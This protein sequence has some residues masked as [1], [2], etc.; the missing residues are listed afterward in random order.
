MITL[1]SP[2]KKLNFKHQDAVSAF[3]QCDFI[4]S[5][6]ELVNQ[7]KNLT[8]QDLKDLMKISDS[9]ANL[10]KERFNNWSLP[11]NQ[12]NSKQAILAFDGGVYS[13]LEAH[14]FNQ[15][16]LDF[17]QD[18]LRILSGLY[19]VLKP[20]DLIQPYRLEM[21][22]KFENAKGKNLYDFW[23][24][25]VTNNLNKNIKKHDNKTIINCSSNE[26]FNVINQN[27]LEGNILNTVFKEYREGKLKFISFNAKKA[28]GLLAKFVINNRIASKNDLKD[29]NLDN[30]K[31]DMSL[32]DES[33]FVFTR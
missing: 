6:Q 14:T 2:S 29:F 8:A 12:E 20:L 4:E 5:A 11:F 22:I 24:H 15:K 27:D 19:G 18:H 7:A 32:S 1:L 30:Y 33:T 31:F 28:R 3:T 21:G 25:E 17:A 13:G 23:S 9:L 10:N 26:Y 16:D